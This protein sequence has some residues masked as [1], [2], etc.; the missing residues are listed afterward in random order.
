MNEEPAQKAMEKLTA[1]TDRPQKGITHEI[2]EM[3]KSENNYKL[4]LPLEDKKLEVV[5]NEILKIFQSEIINFSFL[6]VK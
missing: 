4:F 2:F 5:S 1:I 3:R 6:H